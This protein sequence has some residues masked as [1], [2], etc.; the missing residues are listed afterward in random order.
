MLN[1]G[2]ALKVKSP[3]ALDRFRLS[4]ILPC[5]VTLPP[6]ATILCLYLI[7]SGLCS[8][9]NYLASY[10][11]LLV[12][13]ETTHLLSPALAQYI[14]YFVISTTR[15]VDPAIVSPSYGK[16]FFAW[17]WAARIFYISCLPTFVL[18]ISSRCIKASIKAFS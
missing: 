12:F 2:L 18:I 15:A 10:L 4:L 3:R 16:A 9:F 5:W 13:T 14:I 1:Y 8:T 6:A 11:F 17:T 7:S